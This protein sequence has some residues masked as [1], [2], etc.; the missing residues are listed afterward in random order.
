MFIFQSGLFLSGLINPY[1]C[2]MVFGFTV[3]LSA[4]LG[5]FDKILSK[6]YFFAYNATSIIIP[7]LTWYLVGILSFNSGE[8]LSVDGSY[9]L[10]S[11]NLNSLYNSSG[12]SNYLSGLKQVSWHQY[13]GF[14]YLGLGILLLLAL[15]LHKSHRK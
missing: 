5:F 3:A 8:N 9:G 11:F 15:L 4:R 7:L 6:K 2:L 1:M 13:E 12:W 10:Y 14:M